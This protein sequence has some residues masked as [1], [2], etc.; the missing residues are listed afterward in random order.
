MQTVHSPHDKFFRQAMSDITIAKAFFASHLPLLVKQDINLETLSLRKESYVDSHLKMVITD[1]LFSVQFVQKP[2]YLYLLAE[3]QSSPDKW[4]P[5]RLL[6]YTVQILKQH[7][8]ENQDEALPIVYPLVFYHGQEEYS[9]STDILAL[10]TD[11]NLAEQILFKP[12]QLVD[13]NRIPDKKYR[14]QVGLS[15]LELCAKHIFARDLLPHLQKLLDPMRELIETGNENMVK[16][17]VTYL[18]TAAQT[19]NQKVFV[20]TIQ[21]GLSA[22]K[23]GGDIMTVAEWLEEKGMKR[24]LEQGI[25]QGLH[26]GIHQGIE[27]HR[28]LMVYRC[29]Q[30]GLPLEMISQITELSI[31]EIQALQEIVS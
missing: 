11:P 29:L 9:Y 18:L 28:T 30:Q 24:G 23:K 14:Q 12:F 6:D 20:E 16:A 25:Q 5:L 17:T 8:K 13:I 31:E 15:V 22:T 21:A 4:M 1:M 10:F 3:H 7:R 2:G 27:K 19:S 26:Q